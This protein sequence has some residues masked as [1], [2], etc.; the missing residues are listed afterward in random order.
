MPI[1]RER[2]PKNWNSI[3]TSVKDAVERALSALSTAMPTLWRKNTRPYPFRMD[4]SY[5]LGT[6][7]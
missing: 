3:A 7:C 6:S 5:S 1:D 4:E 2:Y